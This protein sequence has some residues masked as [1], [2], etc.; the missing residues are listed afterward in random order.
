[1]TRNDVARAAGV[2]PAVVSYVLN[3]GPRPVSANARAK[4]LAAIGELGYKPDG[5]ARYL[6]T[7]KTKSVG[8]VIPDIGLPYFA[9][10]T[11]AISAA[12][13]RI[14]YQLLIVNTDWQVEQ[15]RRQIAALVERRVDAMVLMSADPLQDFAALSELG[16]PVVVIDRPEVAVQ[17]SAAATE[18]LI[19]HGHRRVA[20]LTNDEKLVVSR[21]GIQ[22]WHE[23]M[24]RHGLEAGD[25]SFTAAPSR[26]GGYDAGMRLLQDFDPP[27]AMLI[28][29]D[30]QAIGI[31]RASADL[32]MSVPDDLAII[33]SEGTELAE[34]SVPRL[35]AIQQPIARLAAGALDLALKAGEPGLRRLTD[36]EFSLVI[37]D[38]C[39][40]HTG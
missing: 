7:G 19:S 12:A 20:I 18:H 31:I 13:Y 8:F 40:S 23:A 24:A 10:F 26:A 5:V 34:F 29:S 36:T 14:N 3:D 30:A 38:S 16:I 35:T 17:S 28:A 11:K 39:G 2:S 37:R 4:V 21:R 15:E 9:E 1:M 33:T 25:L 6:R 32:G 27:T 22:G